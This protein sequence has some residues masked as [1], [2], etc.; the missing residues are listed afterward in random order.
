MAK[1]KPD[2]KE[3]E[4]KDLTTALGYVEMPVKYQPP[5]AFDEEEL[6]RLEKFA[7]L[8]GTTGTVRV[9]QIKA[10]HIPEYHKALF[11]G[12]EETVAEMLCRKDSGWAEV[13]DLDS[14]SALLDKGA[15]INTPF[16]SA[17]FRRTTK[18]NELVMPGS[19]VIVQKAIESF[20]QKAKEQPS[21]V[22][23]PAPQ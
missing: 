1:H 5:A 17:W 21:A 7:A 18:R 15:E 22:T 4:T 11:S 13:V 16:H 3:Q 23:S 12:N 14:L 9:C 2:R 19:S 10:R 8:L 20:L 6:K